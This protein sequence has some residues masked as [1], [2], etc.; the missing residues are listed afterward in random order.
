MIRLE[1]FGIASGVVAILGFVT[2][3]ATRA[4]SGP[5]QK[6]FI[7]RLV[8]GMDGRLSTSK[9]QWFVWTVM[10]LFA[11]CEVFTERLLRDLDVN[12][13]S[14]PPYLLTAMG[15]SVAT[16]SAAKGITSS[17]AASGHV[18]KSADTLPAADGSEL[19]PTSVTK[20][21]LM[22]DDD[23][24][25]DL[26]KIQMVSFT[27]VAL[28]VYLIHLVT[29]S[30][31]TP[32]LVDIEPS[33]MVLMGL[34]QGAYIGKKLTTIETPRVT[35][36]SP[37][38]CRPATIVTISGVNFG[39]TQGGS[40]LTVEGAAIIPVPGT[41]TDRTIQF[42]WPATHDWRALEGWR[43]CARL[44]HRQRPRGAS[45]DTGNYCAESKGHHPNT[46][47]RLCR[48]RC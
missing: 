18:D 26:S 34:S 36:L 9:F 43:T 46:N 10:G 35:G 24:V 32:V 25:P 16:M 7:G 1:A 20:G 39:A 40:T 29:Q 19:P 48:D 5:S 45:T 15:F 28:V 38:T 44:C 13:P 3:V 8:D 21:G 4:A 2:W 23:G 31:E 30:R 11:F 14:L 41:W 12:D 37:A 17:Y 47:I 42:S 6:N 33:L 22:T 27:L